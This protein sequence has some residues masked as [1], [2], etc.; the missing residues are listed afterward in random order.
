MR[1]DNY[2]EYTGGIIQKKKD[3]FSRCFFMVEAGMKKITVKVGKGLFD[4]YDIGDNV[5]IG[6]IKKKLINI[7]P[8]ELP[9]ESVLWNRFID[10]VYSTFLDDQ[11]KSFSDEQKNAII[12]F[13]YDAEVNSGGHLTFFD[14]FGDVF[15]ND[16]VEKALQNVG[17]EKFA[18]NFMSAAAHIHYTDDCGY[19]PIDDRDPVEDDL[20]YGMNPS[21]PVLLQTYI[22]D[23]KAN[24]FYEKIK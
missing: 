7:R 13:A 15:S 5:T 6:H 24:I 19:M 22:S 8:F 4:L 17:G 20:Y 23:N 16:E 1:T 9:P 2:K 21:L 3:L 18:A 11:N 12:A 14:C 10:E